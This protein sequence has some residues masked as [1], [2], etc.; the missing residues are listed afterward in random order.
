[1]GFDQPCVLTAVRLLCTGLSTEIVDPKRSRSIA[2][3]RTGEGDR[4]DG[5]FMLNCLVICEVSRVA[6]SQ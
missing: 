6:I 1:M 2:L 3:V 4:R 5:H